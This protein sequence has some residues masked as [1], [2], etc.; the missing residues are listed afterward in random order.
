HGVDL[1]HLQ[2]EHAATVGDDLQCQVGFAVGGAATHGRAHAG[3]MGGVNEVH[4]EGGAETLGAI[5]GHGDGL[6]HH[7]AHATFVNVA[8]GEDFDA[9]FAQAAL[10]LVV[11]IMHAHQHGI[12][13][14]QL[15]AE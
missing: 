4:V 5:A 12:G 2:R 13:G 11:E 3:G 9:G 6:F 14:G 10:F 8:H 15:G 1:D 7:G